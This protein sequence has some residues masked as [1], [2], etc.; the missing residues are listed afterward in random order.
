MYL[1]V[2]SSEYLVEERAVGLVENELNAFGVPRFL[3]IRLRLEIG[4]QWTKQVL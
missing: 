2:K 4:D 1:G 3:W